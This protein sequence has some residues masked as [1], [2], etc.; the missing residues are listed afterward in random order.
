MASE[1]KIKDCRVCKIILTEENSLYPN[2][3]NRLCR[4]HF[5]EY[6]TAL[7][8]RKPD[9]KR[10]SIRKYAIRHDKTPERKKQFLETAKR[11]YKKYPEKWKARAKVSHAIKIGVLHRL[12]CE[13]CGEVKSQAHHEDYTK[14]LEVKWVCIKHHKMIH[15]PQLS[16][17]P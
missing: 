9:A 13:V 11:M 3:K 10:R 8:R 4:K 6:Q 15:Y 2:P 17:T 12:P 1:T 16:L 7:R 14:P 5:Y